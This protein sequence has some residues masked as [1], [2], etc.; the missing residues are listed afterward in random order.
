MNKKQKKTWLIIL[1]VIVVIGVLYFARNNLSNLA[2][3][4]GS[5]GSSISQVIKGTNNLIYDEDG[6]SYTEELCIARPPIGETWL[7]TNIDSDRENARYCYISISDTL[8]WGS[9][10]EVPK[11]SNYIAISDRIF[12]DHDTYLVCSHSSQCDY[13]MISGVR[14]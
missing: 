13:L 11:T 8:N 14:V 3:I 2:I 7:I 1:G 4:G 10:Y 5:S 9:L 12:I 6:N